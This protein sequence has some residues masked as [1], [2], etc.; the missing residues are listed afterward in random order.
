MG[1]AMRLLKTVV[2]FC[3]AL[4][5]LGFW[6]VRHRRAVDRAAA[7]DAAVAAAYQPDANGFVAMPAVSNPPSG[8]VW[9]IAPVNCP[10]AEA[11]R[12]DELP[13]LL[14]GEGIVSVR[15]NS[16]S[17]TW[18]QDPGK[19]AMDSVNRVMGGAGP[20]VFVNGRAG[21]NPGVTAIVAEYRL[22]A[23]R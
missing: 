9:I 23:G 19:V 11:R 7:A 12:A 1:P 2:L 21:N 18:D 14:F 4:A 8:R 6:N 10:S 15:T 16:V 13:S 5:A 3:I 20:I 22:G 17:L